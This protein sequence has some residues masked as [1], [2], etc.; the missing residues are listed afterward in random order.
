M[1]ET[2]KTL[3]VG[4]PD[5][6][7]GLEHI[8]RSPKKGGVVEMIVRRPKKLA[9]EVLHEA[10]LDLVDGLVGDN[11][12]NRG[13]QMTRNG[14]ADPE[15][16]ITIM[17]ARAIALVAQLRERWPL[18]GDQLFI[19]L[20]LSAE[21]IP[22]GTRLLIGSAVVEITAAPHTGCGQFKWRFG[23]LAG[24]FWA[25]VRWNWT[26][27]SLGNFEELNSTKTVS[28]IEACIR[29]VLSNPLTVTCR[30]AARGDICLP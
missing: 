24:A 2:A 3:Y 22:S 9:R 10:Q 8:R 11:W 27:S 17:N 18:A 28:S 26:T 6:Q 21:N 14:L 19:D 16:Q 29:S 15:R 12:K 13:S 4:M 1:P 30:F 25:T 7:A 5:L 20:D 23:Q